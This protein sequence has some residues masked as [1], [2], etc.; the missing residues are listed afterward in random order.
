MLLYKICLNSSESRITSFWIFI[1]GTPEFCSFTRSWAKEH[2]NPPFSSYR[3]F[4]VFQT[5]WTQGQSQVLLRV[6][7]G[8]LNRWPHRRERNQCLQRDI[9][10][11]RGN[12]NS[13][14]NHSCVPFLLPLFPQTSIHSCVRHLPIRGLPSIPL[15][16][17][18]VCKKIPRGWN[19]MYDPNMVHIPSAYFVYV[20]WL[21][22]HF[23]KIGQDPLKTT[24]TQFSGGGQWKP[25]STSLSHSCPSPSVSDTV[26]R[27]SGNLR[28]CF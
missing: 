9:V 28:I 19:T 1:S 17:Q 27:W 11:C 25:S 26:Y 23:A 6:V 12:C 15:Y 16:E 5:L 2:G 18:P 20:K 21:S 10:Y 22:S 24:V 13:S 4:I 14:T 8:L 7:W 3:E